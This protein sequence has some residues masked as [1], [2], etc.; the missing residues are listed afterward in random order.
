LGA[1]VLDA[2]PVEE[3]RVYADAAAPEAVRGRRR[4]EDFFLDVA[5][6]EVRHVVVGVKGVVACEAH[7][8]GDNG[9]E[10]LRCCEVGDRST[11]DL[12]GWVENQHAE[13]DQ[14]V[15]EEDGDA[16]EEKDEKDVDLLANVFVGKSNGKV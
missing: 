5:G 4:G 10:A 9:L 1:V 8:D 13:A 7:G 16:E 14:R 2:L 6:F 12:A 15:A 11:L 3:I